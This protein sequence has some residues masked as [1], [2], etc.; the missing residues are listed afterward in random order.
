[1]ADPI[2]ALVMI[3]SAGLDLD[4][5]FG[6]E[7][8]GQMAARMPTRAIVIRPSGGVA[9]TGDSFVEHDAQRVDLFG[10]GA[11]PM[12]AMALVDQAALAL[13]R[14]RRQV[15]AGTLIH[16]VN[17]AGGYSSGREPDT[18]WPRAWQ[19]FQLFYALESV[20]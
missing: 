9:L 12:E 3:L 20:A 17:S 5:V 13:R 15:A 6:G 2:G 16:W 14:V 1:M 7:L 4:D 10:Y 19:S 8:P 18:D 11:T